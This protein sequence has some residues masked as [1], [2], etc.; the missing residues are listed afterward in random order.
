M[1]EVRQTR[2]FDEWLMTV[3]D[4]RLRARIA[5]RIRSV[6]QGDFGDVKPAGEGLSELRIHYGPGVRLYCVRRGAELVVMLGGGDK[7]TQTRDIA[8]AIRLA[9]TL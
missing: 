3:T 7:S 8:A 5:Q 1:I 2:E 6:A 4:S 9:R